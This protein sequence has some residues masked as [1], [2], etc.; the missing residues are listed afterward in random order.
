[1]AR[2]TRAQLKARLS[3]AA[4]ITLLVVVAVTVFAT[5]IRF[6][7]DAQEKLAHQAQLETLQFTSSL[8]AQLGLVVQMVK[9]P[10]IVKYMENPDDPE[11]KAVAF[12]E[13]GSYMESYLSKSVFFVNDQDHKFYQDLKETYLL[14]PNKPENYWYNMTMYETDV[15]NFN[16]NYNPD[17]GATFLWVN[18]VIRNE[19]G[20][21]VGIAGTGIPLTD[22]INSMYS[23]LPKDVTMYIYDDK[24]TI[25]GAEDQS[26]LAE[27]IPVTDKLPDL[28][29]LD[30]L[31]KDI[32]SG[33]SAQHEFTFAPLS[34]V[35]WHLVFAKKYSFSAALGYATGPLAVCLVIIFVVG[36]I[37]LSTNMIYS[38]NTLKAAVDDLS[39]GNADLT[40]RVE[41]GSTP[42]LAVM[43][44]LVDSLNRFIQKLQGI[45]GTVKE[46]NGSLVKSGDRLHETTDQTE[47]SISQVIK[48][49]DSMQGQIENQVESVSGT[50]S[51]VKQV[52]ET[53]GTLGSLIES[54]TGGVSDA[55]AA[56]E[57]MIGNIASVN[58]SVD[59]M[60]ASFEGLRD[61]AK[62]G[63]NKQ[64]AVNE[65]IKQI[66]AQSDMLQ[67][68]NLA[69]SS[70]AEQTNLLAMNAAIEAAHAG[71]AGKG[72]AVVADEIRKLSETSSS[73]SKTIGDQLKNIKDSISEV[74][75]ASTESS[76]AFDSVS[77][78][79]D[80]TDE[81]V[82]QIK[83]AMEEQNAGS[84][85]I[86]ETLRSM[87]ESTIEVRKASGQMEK[88]NK[89]A[90]EQVARLRQATN[91]MMSD[92][93]SLSDGTR[94]IS[95]TG[96]SLGAMVQEVKD[97]IAKIGSQ[98]DQF[99]V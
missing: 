80:E 95:D 57:Q 54:Q 72:F 33:H 5:R 14:D 30:I 1:M 47:S 74:V 64:A 28:A 4:V 32:T 11:L 35:S 46:S 34:L 62:N 15:Y 12:E 53:I 59:K 75:A 8:N 55:S 65:K 23:D 76:R 97:S 78:K 90:L 85:Q 67:E 42:F 79:I 60:A 56:V 31:P 6:R 92:M 38:A 66:E 81:L 84:R 2:Q 36:A 70:I 63:I 98:I 86:R 24:L 25:T 49:I 48:S 58:H 96:N 61:N 83:G 50:A 73:Q 51:T 10:S 19:A 3:A 45:M 20:R 89:A 40:R 99:K 71:E 44:E 21:P 13:L 77:G 26:L 87:N 22:F 37:L 68:A 29:G 17:L 18:A 69:I 27:G 16:I 9:T 94:K 41:L 82:A 7:T 88:D 39:S 91:N 93:N 43:D 52:A